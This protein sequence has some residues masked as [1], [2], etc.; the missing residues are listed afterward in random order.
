[1]LVENIFAVFHD[2]KLTCI[3]TGSRMDIEQSRIFYGMFD[4][5]R[6]GGGGERKREK[7]ICSSPQLSSYSDSFE[8]RSFSPILSLSNEVL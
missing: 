8:S 3:A 7:T 5:T 4:F 1:M 2:K 6:W